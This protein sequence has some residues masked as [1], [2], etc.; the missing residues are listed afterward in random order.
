MANSESSADCSVPA[1]TAPAKMGCI[2][3]VGDD[4][5]QDVLAIQ[6][7]VHA[8]AAWWPLP[9]LTLFEH[10]LRVMSHMQYVQTVS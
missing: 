9:H 10:K 6:V 1:A 2:F 3:K 8:D 7:C 5:R 4:I